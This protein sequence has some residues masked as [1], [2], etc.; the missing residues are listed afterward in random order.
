MRITLQQKADIKRQ[1]ISC[2]KTDKEI[3]KIVIFGSFV[4]SDNPHDIDVAVFQDSSEGYLPLAMK[5]RS[6]TEEVAKI[7]PLDILPLK[8]KVKTDP[9]LAEIAKGEVIYER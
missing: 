5:Y 2:L 7:M 8:S 4:N 6:R 9:F 3:V 1:L